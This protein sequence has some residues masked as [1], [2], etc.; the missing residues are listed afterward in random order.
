MN[1]GS[2]NEKYRDASEV[3]IDRIPILLGSKFVRPG[4]LS[5]YN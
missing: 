2:L 4:M 1:I 5:R 3:M